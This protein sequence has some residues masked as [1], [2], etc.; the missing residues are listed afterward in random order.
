MRGKF[1]LLA[2]AAA[3]AG[4]FAGTAVQAQGL[5]FHGYVRTGTGVTSEGGKQACFGI[6][7]AKYRLGNEC[8]TYGEVAFAL[9]FGKSDGAWAKYNLMLALIEDNAASDFESSKDDDFDI[10]SR[11]H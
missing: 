10:A 4:A 3:A 6:A 9:P 5:E 8:E 1:K 11:Q 7:P 2:L